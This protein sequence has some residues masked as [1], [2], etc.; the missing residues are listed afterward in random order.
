[1]CYKHCVPN[2]ENARHQ[3]MYR[4]MSN[5]S[6]TT[7][8]FTTSM[9]ES[10]LKFS[11]FFFRPQNIPFKNGNKILTILYYHFHSLYAKHWK[12]TE[13]YIYLL[14]LHMYLILSNVVVASLVTLHS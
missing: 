9:I 1:M 7:I 10:W 6:W 14:W 3:K 2:V 12:H 13:S 5:V 8:A 4:N 11:P